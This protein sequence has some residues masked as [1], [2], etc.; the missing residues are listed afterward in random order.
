MGYILTDLGEEHFVKNGLK[1]SFDFG[2]YDDGTDAIVD[3]DDVGA[4]TT[5]PSGSAYARQSVTI[6][7][8]EVQ[9]LSGDWGFQVTVTFDT[10]DSSQTSIDGTFGVVNFQA[11]DTGDASAQD[12]L[13]H[14]AGPFGTERD[15]S[16][17]DTLDVTITVT[18][19]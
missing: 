1:V 17:V 18:V 10:S 9:D 2:L 6:S 11:E 14:T 8:T 3:T 15:L 16:N 7:S 12:H 13:H 4:I 5:E 19:S